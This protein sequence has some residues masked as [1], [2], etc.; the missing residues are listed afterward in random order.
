MMTKHAIGVEHVRIE[1]TKSFADVRAALESSLPQLEQP[2]LT[3]T[4]SGL[5]AKRSRV[6]NY[7]F[8]RSV[9]MAPC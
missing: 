6:R 9:I 1:S 4:S 5:I 3:G 8:S 2:W 7:Q